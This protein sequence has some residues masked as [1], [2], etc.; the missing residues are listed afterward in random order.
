MDREEWIKLLPVEGCPPDRARFLVVGEYEL[1]VFHLTEP[2]RFVVTQGTCP[3]AGAN[4]ATGEVS[5]DV[6]TC[7]WHHW[8]FNLKTGRC[9]QPQDASLR[10]YESLLRDGWVWAKLS[11]PPPRCQVH[12]DRPSD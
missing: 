2:D 10:I 3:H 6:L 1:A 12:L 4:L 9:V 5:G 8:A 11:G 7:S